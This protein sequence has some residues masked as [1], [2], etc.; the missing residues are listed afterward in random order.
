MLELQGHGGPVVLRRLLQRCL[1]LGARVAEPGEFTQ[2]A[3]LNGKLDLVQAEGV[4]DLID[5][6]DRAGG[7]R[8]DAL[9]AGRILSSD[10]GA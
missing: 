9:A 6:S 7:A 10:S 5:A 8:R 1:E 3:F 2:R 4:I